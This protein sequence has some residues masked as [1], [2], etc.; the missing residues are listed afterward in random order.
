MLKALISVI[1]PV[2][3]VE[4][5]WLRRSI[6]SIIGQ[7]YQN[8]EIIIV[9]DGSTDQSGNMIMEYKQKIEEQGKN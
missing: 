3:K 2:Y 8:I 9:D 5:K 1:V 6:E 7:T 4:E